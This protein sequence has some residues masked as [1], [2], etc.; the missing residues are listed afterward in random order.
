MGIET[1]YLFSLR[2]FLTGEYLSRFGLSLAGF[3][4]DQGAGLTLGR[5]LFLFGM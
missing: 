2:Y 1:N 4:W 5:S 3:G